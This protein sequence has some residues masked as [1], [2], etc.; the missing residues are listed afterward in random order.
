MFRKSGFELSA[1]AEGAQR[2]FCLGFRIVLKAESMT[3]VSSFAEELG[4]RVRLKRRVT[5]KLIP[6]RVLYA[7]TCNLPTESYL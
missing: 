5:V 3:T 4:G 7:S 2:F 1:G 6:F